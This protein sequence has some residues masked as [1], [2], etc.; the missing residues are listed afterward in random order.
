MSYLVYLYE[1]IITTMIIVPK[2]A[3]T[4][5]FIFPQGFLYSVDKNSP[6]TSWLFG[7]QDYNC[8]TEVDLIYFLFL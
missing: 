6:K 3:I 8:Q 1:L 5:V 2:E 7:M 4:V